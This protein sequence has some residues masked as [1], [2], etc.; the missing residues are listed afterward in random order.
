M[1]A[2]MTMQGAAYQTDPRYVVPRLLIRLGEVLGEE[3]CRAM[4]HYAAVQEGRAIGS[5]LPRGELEALISKI[6]ETLGHE[7]QILADGPDA[8][9]LEIRDSI[10][11]AVGDRSLHEIV[12]GFLEGSLGAYRGRTYHGRVEETLGDARATTTLSFEVANT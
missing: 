6:D 5:D 1:N 8:V 12:V 3:A 9:R 10:L 4:F 7:S 11:L 2:N